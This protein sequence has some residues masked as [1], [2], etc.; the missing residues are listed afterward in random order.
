M[1]DPTIKALAIS[2]QKLL[3]P[4]VRVLLRHGIAYANFTD[5]VKRAYI[6]VARDDF[7]IQGRKQTVSRISVLTGINRKE[8]KRLL[9]EPALSDNY[10]ARH[11][12]AARVTGGWLHSDNFTDASGKPKILQLEGSEDSFS[13]LVKAHS[14]DMPVRA[15][16]DELVRVGVAQML[17]N[18]D[19]ELI[20]HGYVPQH[21]DTDM[22][23]LLG[24]SVADL[25]DTIDHNLN[26]D[27]SDSRLQLSVVYDNLPAEALGRFKTLSKNKAQQLLVNLDQYL[28]EHDRDANPEL[29]GTGRYRAGVGIYYFEQ[30]YPVEDDESDA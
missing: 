28:V 27:K 15:V 4:L 5:W 25:T 7:E 13:A 22:L 24:D 21:S 29:T 11:N 2:C 6:D 20:K 18:G 12:R 16:L 8:V 9:D 26:A 3:R 30:P 19:V 23:Y 17:D 10:Q 14:G 1:T